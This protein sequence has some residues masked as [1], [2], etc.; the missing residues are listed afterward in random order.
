MKR[1]KKLATLALTSIISLCSVF[2]GCSWLEKN[3]SSATAP[4]Y[5]GSNKE[6]TFW[7][8]SGSCGTWYERDGVRTYFEDGTRM[9]AE[10]MKLYKEAGFNVLF[11]DWS[12]HNYNGLADKWE[13]SA[14]K[15]A[16]DL[17]YEEGLKVFVFEGNL[18]NLSQVK[19]KLVDT[20]NP[21]VYNGYE[22]TSE[23]VLIEFVETVLKDIKQHPAF[24]GVSL[25]D[26]AEYTMFPAMGEVYRAVKAVCP[27]A[28]VNM[29][30]N[31]MTQ[32]LE[33][34]YYCENGSE[35]G[36]VKAYKKYIQTY[37][38]NIGQ[39]CGYIQY[40]DYPVLNNSILANHLDNAQIVAEYCKETG[41]R[42]GKVFQTATFLD[43]RKCN[44]RDMRWQMNIGMAMGI[45]DFSYW[46]YYP[47][48]S[49]SGEM[50][51]SASFVDRYGKPNDIYPVMKKLH[52]EM[53]FN[54]KALMNFEYQG[55]NYYTKT[56]I[57]GNYG[58]LSG[59][60]KSDLLMV[61]SVALDSE[62][63]I[64]VTEQ[65]DELKQQ[66]GYYIVN[67]TDPQKTTEIKVDITFNDCAN[68]QVYEG[69]EAK[70]KELKDGKISFYLPTGSG[71]FV[72]PY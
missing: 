38:E 65:Y 33:N 56:P 18:W 67:I 62:G 2:S 1:I 3:N 60:D 46:T 49:N 31:P 42:F 29:N 57:P 30:I 11:V 27:D 45:K 54:A 9:T 19:Q 58:Y 70:N 53:Q 6:Y 21:Y 16:M 41:M 59:V 50:D 22:F 44:E 63:I 28:F 7:A 25:K 40:D 48:V 8:Y 37:Y 12:V 5:S 43:R 52:Q 10:N 20:V 35:L 26:E 15:A 13:T 34:Q 23:E 71:V 47:R 55:L 72:M 36:T 4:D 64:L 14:L 68:V 24:Y 39:Y 17:A 66:Y 32:G 51:E 61:D 69:G